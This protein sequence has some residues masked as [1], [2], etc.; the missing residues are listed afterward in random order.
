VDITIRKDE[1]EDTEEM[2]DED[3]EGT[4]DESSND[5][6]EKREAMLT[7]PEEVSEVRTEFKGTS[8]SQRTGD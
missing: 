2:K 4:R 7:N 1:F 3:I 8:N 5:E 6:D